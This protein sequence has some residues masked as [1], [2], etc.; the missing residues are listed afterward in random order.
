MPSLSIPILRFLNQ[1]RQNILQFQLLDIQQHAICSQW[2]SA[3]QCSDRR[4]ADR[5]DSIIQN[6]MLLTLRN[7]QP[8]DSNNP[9]TTKPPWRTQHISHKVCTRCVTHRFSEECNEMWLFQLLGRLSG[10]CT[11]STD[12]N[13]KKNCV[14]CPHIASM[15]FLLFSKEV[16]LLLHALLNKCSFPTRRWF[17]ALRS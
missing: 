4:V 8:L 1:S 3:S 10:S 16:Q 13:F 12:S 5:T 9:R 7:A 14:F 17:L 11:F 2:Q 6:G 15:C